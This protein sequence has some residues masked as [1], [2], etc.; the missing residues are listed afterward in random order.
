M[1][2]KWLWF[3]TLITQLCKQAGVSWR[4]DEEKAHPP[5]AI[6]QSMIKMHLK[7]PQDPTKPVQEEPL[8]HPPVRNKLSSPTIPNLYNTIMHVQV[9]VQD[10]KQTITSEIANL[11]QFF[12]HAFNLQQQGPTAPIPPTPTT[13]VRAKPL[14]ILEING[15]LCDI[16]TYNPS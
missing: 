3:P 4:M 5:Q 14:L 13:A 10:V 6:S 16:I 9:D 11:R 2:L 7:G 8:L 15:V 12:L 1:E